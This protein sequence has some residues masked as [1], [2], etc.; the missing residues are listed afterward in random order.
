M[1]HA[2]F[3]LL[4]IFLF[5]TIHVT[6]Q[7]KNIATNKP[8]SK[9]IAN[10]DISVKLDTVKKTIT[11]KQT[12]TWINNAHVPIS[13]LHFH[14]YMN[15]FKNNQSTFMKENRRSSI[16]SDENENSEIVW[17]W[18][19]IKKIST[20]KNQDILK[21]LNY[22]SP[23]D[24]NPD[25]QT[26]FT[27]NLPEKI[28]PG[29]TLRLHFEFET[30]LPE[31]VARAGYKRNFFFAG[32]WFPKIGVY[33]NE[34]ERGRKTAGWNCHQYHA[35]SEF[36]ADF[37]VYNV[38]ITLPEN[39]IVAS[40]GKLLN[41]IV[42]KDRTKTWYF[43]AEDIVDF[44]WTASQR[45]Q[46]AKAKWNHVDIEV[47]LQPEH[48]HL[49]DNHI[50]SAMATL[51]FFADKLGTYPYTHMSIIDPPFYALGSAGME[52]TT[53]FTVGSL[54]YNPGIRNTELITVHELG[55]AFFM[56]ILA[57]NEFEEPWMDEG[58]NSYFEN[59][60][61]DKTYGKNNSIIDIMGIQMG[62]FEESRWSYVSLSNPRK[63]ESYRTSWD[64]PHGGYGVYNYSKPSAMLATFENIW[65]ED[66][67]DKIMKTYYERWKFKHPCTE[68][69]LKIVDEVLL[70]EHG[71]D[72]VKDARYFFDQFLFGNGIADYAV[73]RIRN[74]K[75]Y[76]R[77]G[78]INKNGQLVLVE[79]KTINDSITEYNSS[80]RIEKLGDVT[81]PIEVLIT[82]ESGK[83]ITEHWN[84]NQNT[85]EFTYTGTDKI[86]SAIIDPEQKLL[87][88]VNFMNNSISL[89]QESTPFGRLFLDFMNF[90]QQFTHFFVWLI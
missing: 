27:L 66:S 82:F 33:E 49:A 16:G 11:G 30:K 45:Y 31:I 22:I 5:L 42:N 61:M 72:A 63:A 77:A 4:S 50:K 52:Y 21:S 83:K 70:A 15:A 20:D 55:H 8:L 64:Y 13:E 53:L 60:I 36:F 35:N 9:R 28:A 34:G 29:D 2:P 10:Y 58:M 47:F 12:L 78:M 26:V 6:G 90:L 68:D 57:S 14:A 24:E 56:G 39:Y 74:K 88:D 75:A 86:K 51:D 48:Y 89:N 38:D 81:L 69:F 41:T 7:E 19:D 17:G 84:G 65:G 43:R 23:D 76:D 71:E 32:Q 25:D 85:T 67:M 18:L 62:D 80:V 87:M 40:G 54:N 59:R 3:Y 79:N 1:K 73:T 44:A 37:G 46:I